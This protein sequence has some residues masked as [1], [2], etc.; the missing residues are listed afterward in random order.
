M[1]RP[2]RR[3][4]R[5]TNVSLP[6]IPIQSRRQERGA[7]R[8]PAKGLAGSVSPSWACVACR[9]PCDPLVPSPPVNLAAEPSMADQQP[10]VNQMAPV[11]Q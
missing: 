10:A 6:L 1:D 3:A 9:L 7:A 5:P 11:K 8:L 2:I 4:S